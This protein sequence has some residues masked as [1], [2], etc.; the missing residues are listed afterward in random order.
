MA[1]HHTEYHLHRLESPTL[2][3]FIIL[4]GAF[5]A[6]LDTS[7]VQVAIP[8]MEAELSASTDQIQWVLTGYLLVLG[9]LVPL[10]GWLTDRFGAKRLFI[11]SI[12]TFTLGSALC[13]MAWNLP[14]I[15]IFRVIQGLGGGFMMPVAMSM[16]YLIFPRSG[17]APPWG[18]LAS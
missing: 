11:F 16:I 18:S 15:I 6:I 1:S 2:Q 3:M 9:V 10:S 12:A 14:S 8:T 13:G 5:M 17:A 7:V 4:L